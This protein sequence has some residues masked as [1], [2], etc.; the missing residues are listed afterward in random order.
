[1]P[2]CGGGLR[3]RAICRY[4]AHQ[5]DQFLSIFPDQTCSSITTGR[6][7]RTP[8][9]GA[10]KPPIARPDIALAAPAWGYRSGRWPRRSHAEASPLS[11]SPR[12]RRRVFRHGTGDRDQPGTAHSSRRAGLPLAGRRVLAVGAGVGHLSCFFL[13]RGCEVVVTEARSEN[14]VELRRRSRTPIRTSGTSKHPSLALAVSPLCSAMGCLPPGEPHMRSAEQ[15]RGLRRATADRDDGVRLT[16]AG[17]AAGQR[18]EKCEP[19]SA[20]H[21]Q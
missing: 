6:G 2:E 5:F 19:G 21:R 10:R 4:V 1:M 7:R 18:T 15:G 8:T 17:H 9:T 11:R 12:R 13:E 16:V 3:P 14:V 20:W